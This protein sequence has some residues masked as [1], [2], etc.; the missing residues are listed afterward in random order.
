MRA[1][2]SFMNGPIGRLARI[3]LGVALIAVGL[4]VVGGTGGMILAAVGLVPIALGV[5]GRCLLEFLA[6]KSP[7]R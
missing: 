2:V 3:G 1:L 5:S 6:P 7:S 4:G